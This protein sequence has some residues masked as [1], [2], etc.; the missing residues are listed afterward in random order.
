M[1][2]YNNIGCLGSQ[3]PLYASSTYTPEP[4]PLPPNPPSSLLYNSISPYTPISTS[5]P[6]P[7]PVYTPLST[8]PSTYIPY[9]T[10][11]PMSASPPF[12]TP[13]AGVV[14]SPS[15]IGAFRQL[16]DR[17]KKVDMER[18]DAIRER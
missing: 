9:S 6:S 14:D 13:L 4:P 11:A 17:A 2:Y 3:V 10:S 8:L 1:E 18:L 12:S 7:A 5:F 16:Q 15:V